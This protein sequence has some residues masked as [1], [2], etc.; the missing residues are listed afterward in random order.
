MHLSLKQ[1]TIKNKYSPTLIPSAIEPVSKATAFSKLDLC[2]TYHLNHVRAWDEYKTAFKIPIGHFEY[3]IMPFGLSNA[4][5][6]FQDMINVILRDLLHKF[7]FVYQDDI[8]IFSKSFTEHKERIR[9]VVK[10]LLENYVKAK[11]SKF[12]VSFITFLGF[13]FCKLLQMVPFLF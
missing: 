12:H 1:I 3:L 4:P 13:I 5:A 9:K 11:K 10:R 6:A 7:V 2:Y 8:L